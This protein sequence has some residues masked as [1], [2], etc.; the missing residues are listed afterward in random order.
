[1]RSAEHDESGGFDRIVFEWTGGLPG[2]EVSYVANANQC[3]SGAAVDLE[4][5]AILM[6]RFPDAAAHTEQG[7]ATF[8][9]QEIDGPGDMIEEAVQVCD[10]EGVVAWAIG[11]DERGPFSLSTLGSPSRVVIDVLHD[12]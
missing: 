8:G 5:D 7:Q 6:V 12:D 10:F 1:V 2:A 9:R 4:G 3:G 11:V